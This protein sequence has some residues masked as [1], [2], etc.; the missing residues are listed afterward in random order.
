MTTAPAAPCFNCEGTTQHILWYQIET[1][2]KRKWWP[3][4]GTFTTLWELVPCPYC[5][6]SKYWDERERRNIR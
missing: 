2:V 4:A 5:A 3:D 6:T 1:L